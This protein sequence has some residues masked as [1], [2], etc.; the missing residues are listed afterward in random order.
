MTIADYHFY[1][2]A[3]LSVLVSRNEFTGLSR[4]TDLGPAY[5]INNMIGLYV[6]HA[7]NKRS[8]WQFTFHPDHQNEIRQL[9]D[10]FHERTFVA[11]VCGDTGICLLSYGQYS[12]TLQ[13]DFTTQKPLN[14]RR[15]RG[16]GFRVS[17][18]G[19]SLR[20]IIPLNRFPE[21]LF[22]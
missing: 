3:A 6:K 19:G 11:F 15:P 7:S 16:H 8:P 5:A 10:R 14:V 22:P 9:F 21:G 2:G 18:Q 20:N 1:H 4:I 13:E 12:A 17:G